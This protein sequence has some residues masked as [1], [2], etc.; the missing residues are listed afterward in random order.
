[1]I[2][3]RCVFAVAGLLG[4]LPGTLLAQEFMIYPAKGQSA[5]QLEQDK[6]A[7]YGFAKG[8]SGFDPMAPPT[9]TTAIEGSR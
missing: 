8:Q 9:T 1:M 2:K 5:E 3:L 7:C 6:F 4:L